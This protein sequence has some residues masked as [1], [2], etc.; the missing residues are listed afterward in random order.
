MLVV[1]GRVNPLSDEDTAL[2]GLAVVHRGQHDVRR[3]PRP[4][5]SVSSRDVA[6]EAGERTLAILAAPSGSNAFLQ[7]RTGAPVTMTR[8]TRKLSGKYE[9]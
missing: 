6:V 8:V 7:T 3:A 4:A 1:F 9:A 5:P 2:R